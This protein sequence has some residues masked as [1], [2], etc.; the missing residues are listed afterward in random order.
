MGL[1]FAD[2][3]ERLLP[4]KLCINQTDATLKQQA[5][6]S[7]DLFLRFSRRLLVLWSPEYLSR[8]WCV[9][10]LATFVKIHPDGSSRIDF[11]P[12]W[13]PTFILL[14]H[15]MLVIVMATLAFFVTGPFFLFAS[16]LVGPFWG[17]ILP[18]ALGAAPAFLI[19]AGFLYLKVSQ[20]DAMMR[21]LREFRLAACSCVQPRDVS[22]VYGLIDVTW[23]SSSDADDGKHNFER[24]VR[25]DLAPSLGD[26]IGSRTRLSYPVVLI[27]FLPLLSVCPLLDLVCDAHM[28]DL[29]GYSSTFSPTPATPISA[30]KQSLG[31]WMLRWLVYGIELWAMVNPITTCAVQVVIA[32]ALDAGRGATACIALGTLTYVAVMFP[33][34]LL[35]V[36]TV[37]YQPDE[38]SPL[39]PIGAGLLMTWTTVACWRPPSWLQQLVGAN[40]APYKSLPEE[41]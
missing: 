9:Y 24:F 36:R 30:S 27:A 40:G 16:G 23:S 10:E 6:D 17:Y 26:A 14:M 13:L 35:I 20:Y 19:G 41:C 37:M 18:L 34:L 8:L 22:F 1:A 3:G 4:Y 5:I 33:F 7:L 12:S 15:V 28:L 31:S 32:K 2:G 38:Q 29:W 39:L 11:V 25:E 21:M